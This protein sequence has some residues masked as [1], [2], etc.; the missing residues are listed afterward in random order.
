MTALDREKLT[1]AIHYQPFLFC[2]EEGGGGRKHVLCGK[3]GFLILF[4]NL[5][6]PSKSF[7]VVS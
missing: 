1:L 5:G 4:E 6:Q 2:C 7:E 3:W